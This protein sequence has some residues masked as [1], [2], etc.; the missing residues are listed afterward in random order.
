[1]SMTQL[2]IGQIAAD[3]AAQRD[4]ATKPACPKCRATR[5]ETAR[6]FGGSLRILC[7]D[8]GHEFKENQA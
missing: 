6:G 4:T 3:A 8:C 2:N 1:M 7:A 5:R